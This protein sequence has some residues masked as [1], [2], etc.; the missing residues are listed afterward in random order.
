MQHIPLA[1]WPVAAA[2]KP[3]KRARIRTAVRADIAHNIPRAGRRARLPVQG[4]WQTNRG[5]IHV[6]R[7]SLLHSRPSLHL[8]STKPLLHIAQSSSQKTQAVQVSGTQYRP[9]PPRPSKRPPPPRHRP[10]RPPLPPSKP[11]PPLP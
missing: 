4:W 11:R 5:R 10:P 6:R 8:L 7:R 1:C 3:Q 2:A 9:R